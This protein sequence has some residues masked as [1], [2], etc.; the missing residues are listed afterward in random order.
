MDQRDTT[1]YPN[2]EYSS[3]VD[4]VYNSNSEYYVSINANEEESYNTPTDEINFDL[5]NDSIYS[6]PSILSGIPMMQSLS[7]KGMEEFI[8][9]VNTKVEVQSSMANPYFI[10]ECIA[11][12]LT[13]LLMCGNIFTFAL[14]GVRANTGADI[15]LRY[16]LYKAINMGT[17]AATTYAFTNPDTYKSINITFEYLM[18]NSIIFEY[19]FFTILKYIGIQIVSAIAS[20]FLIIGVYYDL[21]DHI[22]TATLL[23]NIFSSRRSYEFS[24]SYVL[25]AAIKHILISTLLTI[26]TNKTTSLDARQTA[27]SKAFVLFLISITFGSVIGPVGYVWPNLALYSIIVVTRGEYDKFDTNLFVTFMATIISVFV[28]YPLIAIQIKFVWLN[29]YRRYIEYRS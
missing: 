13:N 2:T 19:K 23:D 17:L 11:C 10:L 28:C 5:M 1:S 27:I 25:V 7:V 4:D 16:V 22:P 15:A 12:T 29:R 21:I 26:I 6:D 24:Y 8:Q 14:I 9:R 20:S 18:I 3:A